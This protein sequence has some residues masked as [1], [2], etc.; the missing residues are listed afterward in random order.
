MIYEQLIETISA[1]VENEKIFKNGLVLT[2]ELDE[3]NYKNMN[4]FF[5]YKSNAGNTPFTLADEFEIE[6]GGLLI[7]FIKKNL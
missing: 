4:E 2:Y 1:I 7:K 3:K 6:M 5:F